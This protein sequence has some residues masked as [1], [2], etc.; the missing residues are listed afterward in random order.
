MI[1]ALVH[2]P[3]VDTRR[4]TQLRKK[5]DPQVDLIGPHITLMFPVP[6]AIGEA[7][8]VAHLG[9]VLRGRRPFPIHLQGCQRSWDDYLFLMVQEG[10][11]EIIGLHSEIHTGVLAGYR[12]EDRP[13]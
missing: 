4:I 10:S 9:R 8:L 12:K 5:Y 2:Y 6:A 13:F 7:N 11:A 3:N 1:Y